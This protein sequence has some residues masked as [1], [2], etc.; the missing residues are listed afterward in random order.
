M[1]ASDERLRPGG[2][3]IGPGGG[4][5]KAR[6]EAFQPSLWDRLVN[7][8]PGLMSEIETLRQALAE[9]LGAEKLEPLLAGGRRAVEADDSLS[10]ESVRRLHRLIALNENRIALERRGIVVSGS[11]LREAVRRDIEALFNTERF[12]SR[13]LLSDAE[14]E[15]IEDDPPALADFPLVRRSVV[16]YGVPSFAGRSSRDFDRDGLAKEIRSILATYEPRL[17]AGATKVSVALGDKNVGLRI[18]IDAVLIMT[19]TPERLRLMTTV[20]LDNGMA[21]TD[22]TDG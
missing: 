22:I 4:N 21:R 5:P 20:N 14:A 19:P 15:Q 1:S 6:R 12:E 7:E 3:N 18:D 9:E 13:P 11:L 17:K 10:P 2:S 8:L 16:N